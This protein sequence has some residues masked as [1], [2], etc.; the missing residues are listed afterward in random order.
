MGGYFLKRIDRHSFQDQDIEIVRVYSTS[1]RL[2]HLFA[3]SGNSYL[4]KKFLFFLIILISFLPS[5]RT[6]TFSFK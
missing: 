4:K 6:F 2:E 5:K 1:A 3:F